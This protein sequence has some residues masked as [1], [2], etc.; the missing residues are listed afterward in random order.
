MIEDR[1]GSAE[2]VVDRPAD[3]RQLRPA[4]T[5]RE[6]AAEPVL[7]AGRR[8]RERSHPRIERGHRANPRLLGPPQVG[9]PPLRPGELRRHVEDP[10]GRDPVAAA[11]KVAS[12]NAQHLALACHETRDELAVMPV[13]LIAPQAERALRGRTLC[14]GQERVV[15]HRRRE[16]PLG[17]AQRDQQVELGTESH[18]DGTDEHALAET[19]D[20]TQVRLELDG[21]RA[22][23]HLEIDR[24]LDLVERGEAIEGQIPTR[25]AAL[26]SAGGHEA[27]SSGPPSRSVSSWRAQS[28]RALH[29]AGVRAAASRRS[30]RLITKVRSSRAPRS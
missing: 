18:G 5:C 26:R 22:G 9:C 11:S 23:E 3:G 13:D 29:D 12:G 8:E 25:S 20:A 7:L 16:G 10:P 4:S 17:H 2:I 27:R 30:M 15:P 19:T 6:D 21:E 14:V 24:R 28:A 1:D